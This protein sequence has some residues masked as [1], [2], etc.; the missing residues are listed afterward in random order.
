MANLIKAV[1]GTRD[2]LP[3]D[4]DTWNSVESTVRELF[5]VYSF[6]EIRTPIIEDLRLFQRSVG[7]ETDIVSKE[8]YTLP[9][10]DISVHQSLERAWVIRRPLN[11]QL[12][13]PQA[14]PAFRYRPDFQVIYPDRNVS[15]IEIKSD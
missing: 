14:F 12:L 9:Q 8:L 1:R 10:G 7:E 4:T 6:R 5:R 3:P 15:F 13:V 2:L 11:V